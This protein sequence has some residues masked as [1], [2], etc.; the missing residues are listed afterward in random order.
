MNG[1][2]GKMRRYMLIVVADSL[3]GKPPY[4]SYSDGEYWYYIDAGDKISQKNFQLLTLFLTMMAIP[5]Q[6]PPLTPTISVGGS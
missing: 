1:W 2:L 5:S 6:T 4:V 3:P